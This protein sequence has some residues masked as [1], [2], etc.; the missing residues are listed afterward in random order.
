MITPEMLEF[1]KHQKES[2]KSLEEIIQTLRKAGWQEA[3]IQAGLNPE[4]HTVV[5]QA[6]KQLPPAVEI[7]KKAWE[8]YQ[9]KFWLLIGISA[10]PA[11]LVLIGAMFFGGAALLAGK[12]A[13]HTP[14]NIDAAGLILAIVFL[15]IL[16][17][18]GIWSSTAEMMAIR[19]HAENLT[20]QETFARAR[21]FISQFFFTNLLAGLIIMIGF[22]LLIVPGII[23]ALWFSQSAYI[24]ICEKVYYTEALKK[25]KSYVSGRLWEVF[26]KYLLIG[27]VVYGSVIL[28]SFIPLLSN[29]LSFA[30]APLMLV[31]SYLLYQHLKGETV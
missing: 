7:L 4:Q 30:L 11:I 25:S 29:V 15:I 19:D 10:V 20:F 5:S 12:T 22:I 24:V 28:T 16:I 2:G 9:K 21:P 6:K 3:D 13:P 14:S 23:F 1:I 17:Y 8:I 31:Y 27:A 18:I 26:A